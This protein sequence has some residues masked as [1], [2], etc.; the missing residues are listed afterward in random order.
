ME[1]ITF[2]TVLVKLEFSHS[3]S[4][5]DFVPITLDQFVNSI[6]NSMRIQSQ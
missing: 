3:E 1:I 4:E 5:S 6:Q 2:W